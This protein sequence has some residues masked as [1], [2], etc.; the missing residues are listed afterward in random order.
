MADMMPPQYAHPE[1]SEKSEDEGDD[2]YRK[3]GYH[4]VEIGEEYNGG[5][6]KTLAKL[7]WGHFSTVWLCW[8][9]AASRFVAMKVQ[10]SAQN[11]TEAA[12][13]EI[14]LL[15]QIAKRAEDPEWVKTLKGPY[16]ELF[17]EAETS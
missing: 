3:G 2:S 5:R 14:D 16:K 10:K 7:G 1:E 9:K 15:S 13:D 12:F 11:Y 17:P 4:R 8:D 6:Y